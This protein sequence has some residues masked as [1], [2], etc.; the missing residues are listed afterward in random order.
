M[1]VYGGDLTEVEQQEMAQLLGA[2]EQ[3]AVETVTREELV[4][5]LQAAGLPVAP[6]DEAISS[7][8]LTCLAPG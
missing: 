4:A 5:A 7:V 1:V 6:T 3:A 2:D 8:A